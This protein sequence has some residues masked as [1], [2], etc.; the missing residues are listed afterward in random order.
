MHI[1]P[2][3]VRHNVKQQI[4]LKLKFALEEG[5]TLTCTIEMLSVT[6]RASAVPTDER[7]VSTTA[8]PC[9]VT[10]HHR[11]PC[12]TEYEVPSLHDRAFYVILTVIA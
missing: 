11:S 1:R 10:A 2:C 6:L 12:T 9:V 5:H 4:L 8:N 3:G 7:V